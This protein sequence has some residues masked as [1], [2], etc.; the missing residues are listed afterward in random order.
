MDIKCLFC[1]EG[2]SFTTIEH[3][4]PESLGNDDLLLENE[5]CDKCQ[6]YL[7]KIENY[8]LHRTP[9]GFWRTLYGIKTK[10]KKLPQV[11]FA[12]KENSSGRLPDS[13]YHHDNI[14]L[15]SHPDFSTGLIF[16][17]IKTQSEALEKGQ[18]KY[19]LTPKAL[20]EIG[21]FIGKIGIELICLQDRNLARSEEFQPIKDYVRR[22]FKD[23]LWPV[24]HSS[25]RDVE[26]DPPRRYETINGVIT[27]VIECYSY[28]LLQTN[29]Y[30]VFNLKTGRDSWFVCLNQQF[31]HPSL[32]PFLGTR[33]N[34]LWYPKSS[35]DK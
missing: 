20:H 4:I 10:K 35:W 26:K 32:V 2:D 6:N 15:H 9:F 29:G 5:I 31:P 14:S 24:F 33:M 18:L 28:S 21:R 8:V 23:E 30:W 27:E 25:D 12:K 19:V 13:S 16:K 17:D 34:T 22:G 3:I 1:D 11:D 7:S